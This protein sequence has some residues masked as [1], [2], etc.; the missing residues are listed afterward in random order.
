[1]SRPKE[2]HVLAKKL[3][4]ALGR[5]GCGRYVPLLRLIPDENPA[6][7]AALRAVGRACLDCESRGGP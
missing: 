2:V 5:A 7:W 3:G 4:A 6:R 1:M